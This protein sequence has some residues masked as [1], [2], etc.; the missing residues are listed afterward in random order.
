MRYQNMFFLGL[1]A[2]TL[3]CPSQAQIA[4]QISLVVGE[5]HLLSEL[6]VKRIAV[7]NGKVIQATP[8]DEKQILLIPEAAGQS[9]LHVWSKSGGQSSYFITVVAADVNRLFQE[10][11]AMVNG[12]A[13]ASVRIVGDKVVLEGANLSEETSQRLAEIAKRYPQIVNLVSKVGIERMIAIDVRMVEIKRSAVENLGVKWSDAGATGPAFGVIG[14]LHR[15][16]AL[17]SGGAA[18]GVPGAPVQAYVP[19]FASAISFATSISSMLQF[20]VQNG[21]AAI[22]AEPRLSCRSG[23]TARFVAGGELPI[24]HTTGLGQTSVSF[25]EYGIKF[26][27]SP[28]ANESGMISAK[29]ATEIS[30]IN[31]SVMVKDV[32][33]LIKRRAETDVNLRENETLVI[34]GLI[35][36]DI[37]QNVDK[38]AGLGD[39]PILGKLFRSRKFQEDQTEL[40][41]LITPRFVGSDPVNVP[42]PAPIVPAA[43]ATPAPTVTLVPAPLTDSEAG[44][45]ARQRFENRRSKIEMQ[46]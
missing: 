37:S 16:R 12:A 14:D 6:Q 17:R 42:V 41:V 45:R 3:H 26:D 36:N 27:V 44:I 2:L 34:A 13:N 23:G 39:I 32:P 24:P 30:A 35:T 18:D 38:V 15:S 28:V 10:V 8:L 7:G 9:T 20:M 29:I 40:V 43:P 5:A 11:K 1:L 19:P 46:E 31:P 25:K 4:R 22:L 21:D 33:G